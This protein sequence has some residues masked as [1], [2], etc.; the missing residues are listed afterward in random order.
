VNEGLN[1]MPR[2]TAEASLYGTSSH[3]HVHGIYQEAKQKAYLADYIDQTC[4]G[5]CKK[6]CPTE[7][8]GTTGQTKARCIQECAR[9]NA[10]CSTICTRPGNP[11]TGGGPGSGDA[12]GGGSSCAPGT[13][14][15]GGCCREGFPNCSP[16]GGKVVCCPPGFPV[17]RDV[18]G[19]ILCFPV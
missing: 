15:A 16:I 10:E 3:Y 19:T 2:F 6:N 18:F 1:T 8:A 11:P 17:A 5:Q 13:P 9:D 14:C 4:L 7:C 12:G